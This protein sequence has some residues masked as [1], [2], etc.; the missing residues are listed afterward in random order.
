MNPKLKL[1]INI[2][3]GMI[4]FWLLITSFFDIAITTCLITV[5]IL[6]NIGF[7]RD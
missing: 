2:I 1:F 7:I 3:I 5:W 4:L 6:V